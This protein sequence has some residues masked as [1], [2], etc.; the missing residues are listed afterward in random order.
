MAVRIRLTRV[1]AKKQPTYRFVVADS[2]SARDGRSLDT[3]GHYNPRSEPIEIHVDAEKATQAGWSRAPSRRRRSSGSS[4]ASASSR[5]WAERWPPPSSSTSWPAP[6]SM[7]PTRSRV[8]VREED[9]G[10]LIELHV[11]EDDMGKVIGRNGSVAKALRTLLK[12]VSAR[13]GRADLAGDR[14]ARVTARRG[15]SAS[16]GPPTGRPS[17]RPRTPDGR[18]RPRPP[19]PARR[20]PGRGAQRRPDALRGRLGAPSSTAKARPLTVDWVQADGPGILVRFRERADPRVGRGPARPLPRGASPSRRCPTT[21][22]TG[23]S[24]SDVAGRDDERRR[25]SGA[26]PTSSEPAAPRCSSSAAARRGE[27]LVP[28][29]GTI[30]AEFAPRE[31]PHRR[32]CRRARPRRRGA[33]A[34]AA[35]AAHATRA[36]A[37][38]RE[39]LAG[40]DAQRMRRRM[41]PTA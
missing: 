25:S 16:R 24:S 4:A 8:A 40:R 7:T 13:E 30:I 33:R 17:S 9:G 12:V 31:G 6:W 23:T 20:R 27:V 29:V 11:A 3:L 21:T 34:E 15:T 39:R 37:G 38:D 1:G 2:R 5:T 36:L 28:V 35:R 41:P 19:R 26:W 10:Q 18:A 22:S 14:P 32:R